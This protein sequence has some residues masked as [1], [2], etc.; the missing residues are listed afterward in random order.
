MSKNFFNYK[1]DIEGKV[2]IGVIPDNIKNNLDYIAT[3][4]YK[5]IPNK[6]ASTYHTWYDNIKPNIKEK[7]DIIKDNQFWDQIC[8]LTDNCIKISAKEMDELYYSNPPNNLKSINLYGATTNY[9]VHKD[10][11]F[12][13][14]N[15]KFYRVIIGLTDGNDSV[16]TS[17]VNFDVSKKINKYD[18]IVFDFDKTYHQVIKEKNKDTPRILLKL[19]F[20]VCENCKYSKE[21]VEFIKKIYLYYEFI[22]R[23]IMKEGTNPKTFIQFCYGVG[24]QL[25]NYN[26]FNLF[27]LIICLVL[28]IILNKK[29]NVK[30]VDDFG[31]LIGSLFGLLIILYLLIVLFYWGRYKLLRIR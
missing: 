12:N 27:F 20:I 14:D 7:I 26:D 28:I 9:D 22:T 11:F 18:Y 24:C 25:S 5:E 8:D 31:I 15:I 2:S 29:F 10:C 3:E 30:I 23:Y 19:H 17:M 13:F 4:Y 6:N 21:Y 16:A 1:D